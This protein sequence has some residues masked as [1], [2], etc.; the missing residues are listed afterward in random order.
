MPKKRFLFAPSR[1]DV[2][3]MCETAKR[4][5][6]PLRDLLFI[7]ILAFSGLRGDELIGQI[8]PGLQVA[9]IDFNR[10][11]AMI[12]GKG[13]K[14]GKAPPREQPLDTETVSLLKQYLE[15]NKLTSGKVFH[16]TTR[17][18]RRLIKQL[19]VSAQVANAKFLSPHSLRRFFVSTV[20]D[21]YGPNEAKDLAGH[22]YLSTTERYHFTSLSKRR[23]EE[24]H[25]RELFD[26]PHN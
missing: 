6:N 10:K 13:W 20:W 16:I 3:A 17:Q 22:A 9:D 14:S 1:G 15:Q 21:T 5:K 19:A 11:V 4:G 25:Y 8:L 24:E 2:E 26:Q 18:L 7:R 23:I 12:Y